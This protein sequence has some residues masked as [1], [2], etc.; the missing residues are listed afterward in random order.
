MYHLLAIFILSK[1]FFLNLTTTTNKQKCC[2]LKISKNRKPEMN[3]LK[4][5]WL[6]LHPGNK[7]K[8]VKTKMHI[9]IALRKRRVTMVVTPRYEHNNTRIQYF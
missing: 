9:Q 1:S 4:N 7:K 8:L 3:Y 2:I 5:N 6:Q